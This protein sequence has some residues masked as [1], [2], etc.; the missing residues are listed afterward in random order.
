MIYDFEWLR[1][2]V[3]DFFFDLRLSN[4]HVQ[5]G[6]GGLQHYW[7]FITVAMFLVSVVIH[8]G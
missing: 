4:L 6:D 5:I 3:F 1:F 7:R 8:D 2:C